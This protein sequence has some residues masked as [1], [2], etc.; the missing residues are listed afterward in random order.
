MICV[1]PSWP[2]AVCKTLS[3]ERLVLIDSTHYASRQPI[4]TFNKSDNSN[5]SSE[6]DILFFDD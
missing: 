2:N 3:V 6:L 5:M 4:T 1:W